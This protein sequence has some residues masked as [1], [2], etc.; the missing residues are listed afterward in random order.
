MAHW[1]HVEI[2]TCDFATSA[3]NHRGKKIL[4]VEPLEHYL[5]SYYDIDGVTCC[6][7]A[8]SDRVGTAKIFHIDPVEIEEKGLPSWL[9]GCSGIDE[10][11]YS[12][13]WAETKGCNILESDIQ[14]TTFSDLC[15]RYDV[16]SISRLQIDTEGH[17]HRILPRVID[18]ILGGM[19]INEIVVEYDRSL[20][21][22][23]KDAMLDLFSKLESIGYDKSNIS[24]LDVFFRLTTNQ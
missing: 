13:V 22:E 9:K 14:V 19:V 12:L 2:G 24:S 8:I 4:L 21:A 11:P 20:P 1:D 5:R 10:K 15:D 7:S 23:Y 3:D 17:E 18:L 6:V 16:T